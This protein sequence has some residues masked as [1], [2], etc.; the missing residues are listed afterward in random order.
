MDGGARFLPLTPAPPLLRLSILGGARELL[1]VPPIAGGGMGVPCDSDV[2]SAVSEGCA[3][4][5]G[6]SLLGGADGFGV[7]SDG[8]RCRRSGDSRSVMSLLF[9]IV[10]GV[11]LVV[12]AVVDIM[13]VVGMA[14]RC[15]EDGFVQVWR[16]GWL[17]KQIATT[18][19]LRVSAESQ[20]GH[21]GPM[22]CHLLQS[23]HRP[24]S[25]CR[26]CCGGRLNNGTVRTRG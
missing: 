15:I 7:T 11:D 5:D 18:R 17:G 26:M 21:A 23:V 9:F 25:T 14:G 8:K 3:E 19:L 22:E 12:V 1:S 24:I 16:V 20:A 6:S 10:L 13:G 4:G 2:F